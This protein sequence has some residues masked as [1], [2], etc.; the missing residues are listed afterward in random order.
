MPLTKFSHIKKKL[1][2]SLQRVIDIN[3]L[4]VRIQQQ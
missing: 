3:L 4:K 1:W 2:L